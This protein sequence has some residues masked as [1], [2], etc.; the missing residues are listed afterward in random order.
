[1]SIKKWMDLDIDNL[2]LLEVTNLE[3][4]RVKQHVLKKHKKAP[5]WRNIAV[6]SIIILGATVTTGFAFPTIASQIPFMDQII[7]YFKDENQTN[8]FE[9]FSTDVGLVQTSNGITV[10]IENAVYDGTNITVSYAIE[11]EH[12]FNDSLSHHWFDVE[13]AIA[14]SGSDAMKKITDT[15]YVGMTTI[16]PTFK[17][18]VHPETVQVTWKPTSFSDNEGVEVKGDWYFAFSVERLEGNLELLNKTVQNKDVTFTLQSIE[19]TPVSTNISYEQVVSDELLQSWDSVTP[20]FKIT[21]NLGHVYLDKLSGGGMSPD[22]FKTFKGTTEFGT[23][24]EEA[25]Q[26][27]I[28]PIG[29]AS[30]NDG[31]GQIEIEL[32]PIVIDLK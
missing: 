10:M 2:E 26:L 16:T 12:P 30:L 18:D 1:M 5:F 6:A 7:S 29:I 31:K 20:V 28:Q 23:I 27:I 25:S 32:D 8:N 11:T 4:A 9:T 22:H 24:Q 17:G 14:A 19:Y 3:K 15:H 13:G 21:D